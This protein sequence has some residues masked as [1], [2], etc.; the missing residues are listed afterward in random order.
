MVRRANEPIVRHDLPDVVELSVAEALDWAIEDGASGA[1]T[2]W[3][4]ALAERQEQQVAPPR[5]PAGRY[6]TGDAGGIG[7]FG[8]ELSKAL[9][10]PKRG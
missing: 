8:T 7:V 4:R 9:E 6:V 1:Q 5:R 10:K 2:L 3:E